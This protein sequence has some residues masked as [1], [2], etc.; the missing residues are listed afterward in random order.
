[1]INGDGG[2]ALSWFGPANIQAAD[3]TGLYVR[4][5]PTFFETSLVC[6][7]MDLALSELIYL[8]V[9]RSPSIFGQ[10]VGLVCEDGLHLPLGHE[11]QT[12][13]QSVVIL[14]AHQVLA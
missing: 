6:C 4:R 1:M 7:L 14:F 2:V 12:L 8:F 10:S 13:V 11:T 9:G 3:G 5:M